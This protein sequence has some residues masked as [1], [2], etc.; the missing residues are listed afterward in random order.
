MLAGSGGQNSFCA[1]AA[2]FRSAVITPGS[3]IAIA[4]PK[5]ISVMRFIRISDNAIP[6]RAGT[7]PPTYPNPAPR[8]VTGIFSADANRSNLLTSLVDLGNTTISGSCAANH[9]SPLCAASVSGSSATASLPSNCR[10]SSASD[11]SEHDA[12]MQRTF[13]HSHKK[14]FDLR[15][16]H[17]LAFIFTSELSHRVHRIAAQERDGLHLII[18]PATEQLGPTI[19]SDIP[20]RAPRRNPVAW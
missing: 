5:L 11:I 16:N 7:H 2:A 6:P 1:L 17:R 8:A 13:V 14:R 3:I 12:V 9:L 19:S 20:T 4:S 10:S 18:I 15:I